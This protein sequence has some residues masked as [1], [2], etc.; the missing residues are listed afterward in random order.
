MQNVSV[1]SNEEVKLSW[2][3]RRCRSLVFTQL[4]L[5]SG[6]SLVLTEGHDEHAFGDPSAALK[7]EIKVLSPR[8]YVQLV[9]GGSIGAAESYIDNDWTS[10]NLTLVIRVFARFQA[11]LDKLENQQSLLS[12]LKHW[13]IHRNNRNSQLQAKKNIMAHYDLGNELYERFLDKNMVY[14]AAIYRTADQSLDDAQLNKFK[15]ICQRLD[16]K[17][18]ETLLEIGTGWG[19]LAIYA[20]QHYGVKVTTTT[21]SEEQYQYA[22]NRIETLGLS[23]NITLLK[24]DY[25]L[26]NGQYDK[27]VS[28]EMIEAV[29][30]EYFATFFSQLNRLLKP[31]GKMLIQAI[32]IAD[33]RFEYY[34]NSVDFIQK[35]IFPGGCLPSVTV[36]NQHLTEH[37]DMVP[38]ALFDIGLD[39]AKTLNEW[40]QRFHNN[41]PEISKHGY[42]NTFKLLWEYYLCY[43]EG[44]FLEQRV[45]TVHLVARKPL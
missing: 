43:C 27:L 8:L 15:L 45:S 25:R 37:T 16:L 23:D 3:E 7:A 24:D 19:G 14:S 10:H 1:Q 9:K 41:W 13:F 21:I 20:A 38:E 32:T 30:K 26:L 11:V 2:V 4:K 12:R 6:A 39:Y 36:M 18:G 34:A 22:K 40:R 31:R 5:L 17:P 42:D 33:Q 29:G 44:A 28:I 35:Y